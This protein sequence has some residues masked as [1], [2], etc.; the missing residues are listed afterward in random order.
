M[1]Q[2][3]YIA[4]G[5]NGEEALKIIM[6]GS[7]EELEKNK[8]GVVSVVFATT[9]K[10]LAQQK[11]EK[12]MSAP[13]SKDYYMVYSVPLDTDLTALDHYPSIAISKEELS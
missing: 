11:I 2:D 4:L 3:E 10:E 13:D 7:I 1:T 6:K 9:N 8:V 12:L 5:L